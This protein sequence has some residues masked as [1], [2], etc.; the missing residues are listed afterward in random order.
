MYTLGDFL[1]IGLGDLYTVLYFTLSGLRHN[2][3]TCLGG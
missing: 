1:Y 2:V 3:L